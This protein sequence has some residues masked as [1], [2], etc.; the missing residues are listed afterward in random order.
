MRQ[1]FN[2]NMKGIILTDVVENNYGN[3]SQ[4]I[5][6]NKFSGENK[7]KVLSLPQMVKN[8]PSIFNDLVKTLTNFDENELNNDAFYIEGFSVWRNLML[9]Y[10]TTISNSVIFDI[11]KCHELARYCLLHNVNHILISLEDRRTAKMINKAFNLTKS[12][13]H[14][15]IARDF[16]NKS[17]LST[18]K[19]GFTSQNSYLRIFTRLIQSLTIMLIQGLVFSPP[20]KLAKNKTLF[21]GYSKVRENVNSKDVIN[22]K[23]YWS[24]IEELSVKINKKFSVISI[25]SN[26]RVVFQK[27]LLR[28]KSDCPMVTEEFYLRSFSIY[29]IYPIFINYLKMLTNALKI[30]SVVKSVSTNN[31]QLSFYPFI[32]YEFIETVLGR[33][34]IHFLFDIFYWKNFF[35]TRTEIRNVF[36]LCEGQSWEHVLNGMAHNSPQKIETFGV[37][38]TIPSICDIRFFNIGYNYKLLSRVL[39]S[40]LKTSVPKN[41]I[42]NGSTQY[43]ICSNSN[44][45]LDRISQAESLRY[46][47]HNRVNVPLFKS[48]LPRVTFLGPLDIEASKDLY[49]I[50]KKFKMNS[51]LIST[52]VPHP[53]LF[54]SKESNKHVEST[55]VLI[56]DSR[57]VITSE[58]TSIGYYSLFKGK[59]TILIRSPLTFPRFTNSINNFIVCDSESEVIEIALQVISEKTRKQIESS[60]DIDIL[61][62]PELPTW[63][64]YL[65][66]FS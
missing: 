53:D 11:A 3:N 41:I 12:L 38:H 25:I 48:I 19:M 26:N 29:N 58:L 2:L 47:N 51:N 45:P 64:M 60:R 37:V 16:T 18:I 43:S 13:R 20:S 24:G 17:I 28:L 55:E 35:E 33:R 7:S 4:I 44:I 49:G 27:S 21:I 62:D 8:N 61:I 36:Y 65:R 66:D 10:P 31:P 40:K 54:I 5:L 32:K 50:Y 42:V 39:G 14:V 59:P 57:L 34:A 22:L 63:T 56:D 1:T 15:K 52:F 6:W 30:I 9:T 23:S 46:T